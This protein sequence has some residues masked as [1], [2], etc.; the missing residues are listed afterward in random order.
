[1]ADTEQEKRRR[2]QYVPFWTTQAGLDR[3][4]E[5]RGVWSR[6]EYMRQ[7]LHRAT[8]SNPPLRGPQ[9]VEEKF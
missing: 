9:Q 2:D 4:E 1:M 7:A 3:I 6:S 8:T 5:L